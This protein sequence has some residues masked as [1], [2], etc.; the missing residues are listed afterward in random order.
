MNDMALPGA[1]AL[2]PE[3]ALPSVAQI[4]QLSRLDFRQPYTGYSVALEGDVLW[5]DIDQGKIVLRDASGASELELDLGGQ[6]VQA[7]R[8]VRLAGSGPIARSGAGFRIGVKGPVVDNNGVHPMI[9]KSGAVYLR[10]GLNPVR[11]D[12]FNGVEKLGLEVEFE[13]PGLSRR[14]IPGSSLVLPPADR[15]GGRTNGLAYR[16]FEGDWLELPDFNLLTPIKTGAADGFDLGV[17]TREEHAGLQFAGFIEVQRDGLYIFHLRS[18][19]GSILWVGEPSMKLDIIGPSGFPKPQRIEIGQRLAEGFWAEVE[20]KV[21]WAR[22]RPGGWQME[23]QNGGNRL[24]V[25]ATE[26]D[27]R[28]VATLSNRWIRVEGFVQ[29]ART[30]D[31]Q[32]IAQVLLTSGGQKIETIPEP[33]QLEA[34]GGGG[35]ASG[36]LP[37]LT[38]AVDVHRLKRE[39]A[40]R[41]YRVQ[42]R[43]VVTCVLPEHQAFTLQDAT[44]GLYVAGLAVNRAFP[45]RTGEYLV[46][47]GVTDPSLFAPIVNAERVSTLG[48]GQL[49]EPVNATWDQLLNGSLDA[50]YVEIQGI[51]TETHAGGMTLLTREG[52]IMIELRL[53]AGGRADLVHYD[54]ALVRVRGCLFASWNYITHQVGMGPLRVYDA[55]VAVDRPAPADLFSI[56]VKAASDLLLFDPQGGVFQRVKV[57]GQIVHVR[58]AEYFMMDGTNGLRFFMNRPDKLEPGDR[59]EVVGFPRLSGGAAPVL[60]EAIARKTGREPLPTPCRPPPDDLV[61]ADYD[62]RWVRVDG[63]LLSLRKTRSDLVL[64][65]RQGSRTFVARLETPR[66][67]ALSPPI[68]SRLELTGVYAA[69]GG[70]RAAGQDI[71]SFELLL[72]SPAGIR[73]L[74]RPSCG[75]CGGCWSWWAP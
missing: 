34:S 70:N 53:A 6:P 26:S 11:L 33:F 23:L 58:G 46:V 22:Q 37:L 74:A 16:C 41:G 45:P 69:Q 59:V 71:A 47:E 55:V 50:Q 29:G 44:R 9:E 27:D 40:Q 5:A 3:A 19:D 61:R 15:I 56:P 57:A 62:S 28:S 60:R 65:M 67:P 18:D 25:E 68:G 8:R 4:A 75:R 48:A 17:K 54:N 20:G 13:G 39:E 64:E 36:N 43:G 12:W 21:N 1:D 32:T 72:H 14:K 38:N 30:V 35:S 49:P 42:I 51:A 52:S 31:G 24:R 10:R 63:L 7:G 66:E 2:P 73:V